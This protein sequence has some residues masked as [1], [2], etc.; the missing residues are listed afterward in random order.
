MALQTRGKIVATKFYCSL[1]I[2]GPFTCFG[3]QEVP[4]TLGS[5]LGRLGTKVGSKVSRPFVGL[6]LS[7]F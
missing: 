5:H 6:K 2:L 1:A 3:L 7:S 4:K